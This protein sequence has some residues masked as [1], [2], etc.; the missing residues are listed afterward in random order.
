MVAFVDWM[1][2]LEGKYFG[3]NDNPTIAMFSKRKSWWDRWGKCAAGAIGGG[4]TGGVAGCGVGGG[5]GVAV[6]G[7]VGAVAEGVGALPGAAS[8]ALPGDS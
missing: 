4:L 7:G 3:Q 8:G 2:T 5:I 1:E 6:G